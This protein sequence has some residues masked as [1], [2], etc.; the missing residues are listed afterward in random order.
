[1]ELLSMCVCLCASIAS[2]FWHLGTTLRHEVVLA[3]RAA[4][5]CAQVTLFDE[6]VLWMGCLRD[7]A[8]K[9]KEQKK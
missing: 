4:G 2:D 8:M 3:S 6:Q 5:G 1:V 9:L 7:S